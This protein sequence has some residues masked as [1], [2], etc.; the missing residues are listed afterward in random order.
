MGVGKAILLFNT[1]RYLKPSQIYN[2]I[3]IRLQKPEQFW[4]YEKKGVKYK[5]ISLWLK[6][7]DDV[8]AGRVSDG[9]AFMDE[10]IEED[11]QNAS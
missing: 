9:L 11:R 1:I 5:E 8:E 3:K 2:Q 10:L 4:K 6:G 7:L